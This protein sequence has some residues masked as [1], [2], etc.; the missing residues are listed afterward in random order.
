MQRAMMTVMM[1][2]TMTV[3]ALMLVLVNLATAA[4]ADATPEPVVDGESAIAAPVRIFLPMAATYDAAA[5]VEFADSAEANDEIVKPVLPVLPVCD[6]F[7]TDGCTEEEDGEMIILPIDDG[8]QDIEILPVGGSGQ[9]GLIY[10]PV[11][12]Q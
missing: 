7:I 10:L 5:F 1:T 4:A 3:V 11:V 9:S 12:T 8:S 2:V 6:E